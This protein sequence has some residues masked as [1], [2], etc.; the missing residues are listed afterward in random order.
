MIKQ[1]LEN[2]R[3]SWRWLSV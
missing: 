3:A 1:E 2:W